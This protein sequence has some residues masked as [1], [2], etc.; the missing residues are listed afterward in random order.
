MSQ[1]ESAVVAQVIYL[2]SR[3][4]CV[5]SRNPGPEPTGFVVNTPFNKYNAIYPKSPSVPR[6]V[7]GVHPS[8]PIHE[9]NAPL[10]DI[11]AKPDATYSGKFPQGSHL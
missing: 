4:P 10:D 11:V 1:E 2:A 5:Q 8:L 9:T 6:Y 7:L 3:G